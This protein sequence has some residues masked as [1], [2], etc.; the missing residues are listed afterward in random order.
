[1]MSGPARVANLLKTMSRLMEI[2]ER[3]IALL[4]DMK[5]TE[6]QDLQRDKIVLAAAY[7]SQISALRADQTALDGLDPKLR[8]ALSDAAERFR[9]TLAGNERSLRAAKQTTDRV[10]T[11]IAKEV[12]NQRRDK[13]GYSASGVAQVAGAKRPV[14]LA[15]DQRT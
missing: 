3:E 14:S 9:K 5:P 13:A 15:L 7:E 6:M 8:A 1:M 12:E 2:L 4:R 10:L 11:A